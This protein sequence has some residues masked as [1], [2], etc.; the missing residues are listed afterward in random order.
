M[1]ITKNPQNR[2]GGRGRGG[3][4]TAPGTGDV[5]IPRD[6]PRFAFPALFLDLLSLLQSELD[7]N[8]DAAIRLRQFARKAELALRVPKAMVSETEAW[9]AAEEFE[10]E[11]ID[12]QDVSPPRQNPHR[13]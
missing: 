11:E 8:S 1:V 10:D 3:P 9:H 4:E 12:D 5:R 2:G 6:S 7:P 13:R